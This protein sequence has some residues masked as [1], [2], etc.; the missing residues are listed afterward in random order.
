MREHHDGIAREHAIFLGKERSTTIG[1]HLKDIE[2]I[3]ADG[4]A[5]ATLYRFV[6]LAS[7]TRDDPARRREPFEA[8]D[9][10]AKVAVIRV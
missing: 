10:V 6:A 1:S 9:A 5:N 2:E 3:S 7:H 4:T 8:L